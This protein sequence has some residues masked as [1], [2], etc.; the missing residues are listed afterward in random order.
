MPKICL[1][2]LPVCLLFAGCLFQKK[3]DLAQSGARTNSTS[4]A[5]SDSPT[6]SPASSL[7]NSTS[8]QNA[9]EVSP[10]MFTKADSGQHSANS[11]P[12]SKVLASH[13]PI[14]KKQS[15]AESFLFQPTKYPKGFE[16]LTIPG[17]R[18]EFVSED[19]TELDGR[20]F[21]G[22]NPKQVILFCHGNGG[23]LGFRAQRMAEIQ[24][25]HGVAVFIFDYRGYGRSKGKPTISGVLA[26]GRAALRKAAELT[27]VKPE[28]VIVM[29]RSLGGAVAVQLA[30]EFQS[31]G[32]VIES[33]FTSFKD[34]AKRHV[35]WLSFAAP[36]DL[37][38]E[39]T[40]GGYRGKVLISHGKKDGVVPFEHGQ[41]LYAAANQ[42][43]QF[44]EIEGGGHNDSMPAQ[45]HQILD[46][47]I[48]SL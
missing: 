27:Q 29:G 46:Q 11:A 36:N 45:Y 9:S 25:R 30:T 28:E 5:F 31:S 34:V 4:E 18:V 8:S 26:D 3:N 23:N 21:R 33:S 19:G 32:L 35:G 17:Q 20:Y 1:I 43:K 2:S 48:K 15:L 7:A 14:K 16:G 10:A 38:S 47:F 39:K 41:R 40:I 22:V 42:P 37:M 24:K 12:S 44:F 13:K 6:H